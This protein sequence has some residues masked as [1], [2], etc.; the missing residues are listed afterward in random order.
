MTGLP[1]ASH[2]APLWWRRLPGLPQPYLQPL[3]CL[4]LLPVLLLP[5]SGCRGERQT[6]PD[7]I[8]IGQAAEPR[9]LDPHVVT[10]GND[11]RILAQ[12]YEGLVR[13]QPGSLD[14][15]PGLAET[16]EISDD[17]TRFVF[18]LRRN[19]RFHDNSLLC[20][21]GVRFNFERMRDAAH[22]FAH[23]GPFP[24]AFLFD[25]ITTIETPD[26]HTVIFQ[27]SEPFAPFLSNL[28]Y[29]SAFIV[30]AEAVRNHGRDFGRNPAG[31]GPYQLAQWQRQQWIELIRFDD[32]WGPR[33]RSPKLVFRPIGDANAR[34]TAMV[35]G[36]LDILL[37]VPADIIRF[38]RQSNAFEVA[39]AAGP[40]LWFLILNTNKPPFDDVRVRRALNYAINKEAMVRDLLQQTADIAHG[41]IPAAFDWAI[42]P[43]LTPYP[44]DPER[45]RALLAKTGVPSLQLH[46]LATSGG[47]GMLEPL[48]MASAIQS[49]LAAIGVD[50]NIEVFEWNTFLARVNSGLS[51]PGEMAQMAWMTNDPDTLPS[52]AL[53]SS[54]LP[55]LGGF[56]S[57]HFKNADLDEL[58]LA[59]R[60]THDRDRRAALY[61]E[62]DR[63]IHAAA[64]W[65]FVA[66]WRQNAVY[67]NDLTGLALEPSFLFDLSTVEKLKDAAP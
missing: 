35:A 14:I 59:A 33:G 58:L 42:D 2:R 22:P 43:H 26:P 67:R 5:L 21:D 3:L 28:A 16:W 1:T 39:E 38:F 61:Q 6:P 36:E 63:L 4:L 41:A 17:G 64:P 40:H 13:F 47:S 49:D 48:A 18:H 19:I 29:P 23:T 11:F 34:L 60:R 37:E 52:L 8:V 53:S 57:G 27:L 46:L 9:S 55:E 66:N 62:A 65:V 50:L 32:Y 25:K 31:T 45:A 7:A 51:R 30:S 56:N 15:G 12:I 44:Y 20:A 24:M 10:T 54:A